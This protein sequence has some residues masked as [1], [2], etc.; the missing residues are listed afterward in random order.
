MR[1]AVLMVLALGSVLVPAVSGQ[2]WSHRVILS[3]PEGMG[4]AAIGDLDSA[5]EGNEVAAVTTAGEVWM[6]SRHGDDWKGTC[7]HRGGGELIMCA[8]GD[9]DSRRSGNE[10]VAVGMVEGPEA[11]E[12]A[13]RVELVYREGDSWRS[14]TIFRDNRMLHGVSVGDVC[15]DHAGNE[16]VVCGFNHRVTVLHLEQGKWQAEVIYVGD[17]RMKITAIADVI[18]EHAGLEVVT[19]GT[20]GK[21]VLMWKERLGWRHETVFSDTVGQSRFAARARAFTDH[22]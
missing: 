16:I 5:C 14:E 20:D 19:C 1:S 3:L 6:A 22:L 8:I 15:P 17:Q 9:A 11:L 12:G 2:T 10:L 4:G 21:V 7:I 13:G 18:E